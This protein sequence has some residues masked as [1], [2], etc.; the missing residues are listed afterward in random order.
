VALVHRP[1]Q[2]PFCGIVRCVQYCDDDRIALNGKVDGLG[3]TAQQR[4]PGSRPEILVLER[5]A[6]A[7]NPANE[8]MH[9]PP[10]VRRSNRTWQA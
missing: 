4:S 8:V 1:P 5:P 6:Q 9:S 2:L 7:I 10:L 3:K